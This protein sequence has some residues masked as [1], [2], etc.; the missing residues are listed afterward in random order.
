MGQG[1]E[2]K[3]GQTPIEL[4]CKCSKCT[5][6]YKYDTVVWPLGKRA[7]YLQLPFIQGG[8]MLAHEQLHMPVTTYSDDHRYV[9]VK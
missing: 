4:V 1:R 7:E 5:A 6:T 9:E 2:L 8:M 3:Y